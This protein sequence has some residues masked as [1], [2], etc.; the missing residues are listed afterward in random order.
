MAL[1][2]EAQ[3]MV[4]IIVRRGFRTDDAENLAA[5]LRKKVKS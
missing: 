4:I 5:F 3:V 2:Q 1:P